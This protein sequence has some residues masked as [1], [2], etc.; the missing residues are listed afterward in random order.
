MNTE[1]YNEMKSRQE[2]EMN[3]FDG[4]FFAFNKK[5]FEKGIKKVGASPTNKVVKIEAGGFILKKRITA[6]KALLQRHKEERKKHRA[7]K[8]NLLDALIYELNN[9]E[10]VITGNPQDA[11]NALGLTLEDVPNNLLND[12]CHKALALSH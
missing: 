1:T 8:K 12:A 7:N 6:F 2:A 3:A 5:Q 9:H 11:L 10:Y 4:I